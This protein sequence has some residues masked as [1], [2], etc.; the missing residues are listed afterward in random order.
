MKILNLTVVASWI[1]CTVYAFSGFGKKIQAVMAGQEPQSD[2]GLIIVFI[3]ACLV[4]LI[5]IAKSED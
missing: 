5:A 4:T 2:T 1:F 3:I